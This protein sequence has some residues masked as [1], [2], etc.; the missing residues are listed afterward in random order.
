[1]ALIKCKALRVFTDF[2]PKFGM[3]HGDPDGS[4]ERARFPSVP[5]DVA[6]K[7]V[8]E[9]KVEA[10]LPDFDA[11]ALRVNRGTGKIMTPVEGVADGQFHQADLSQLD[12][13]GDGT[14]GGSTTSPGDLKELR[15]QYEAVAG[16]RVFNGW[17]ADELSRRIAALTI[18]DAPPV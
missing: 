4:S 10:A 15:A 11:S 18:D 2:V 6:A 9:G 7:F 3:V 1:M 14:P 5:E 13:D 16:K 12:H 17:D 8:L